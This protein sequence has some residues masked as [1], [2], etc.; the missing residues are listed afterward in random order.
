MK[1][2]PSWI[3]SATSFRTQ[4]LPDLDPSPAL[5]PAPDKSHSVRVS[6]DVVRQWIKGRVG[7]P[8]R[9]DEEVF[10]PETIDTFGDRA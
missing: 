3:A 5:A 6:L 10:D 7:N 8:V 9:V 1:P 2:V 4:D